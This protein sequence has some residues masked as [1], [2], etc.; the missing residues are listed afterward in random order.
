MNKEKILKNL[1]LSIR[2]REGRSYGFFHSNGHT[3]Q[4]EIFIISLHTQKEFFLASLSDESIDLFVNHMG[5]SL[6]VTIYEEKSGIFFE[7]RVTKNGRKN[8][9]RFDLTNDGRFFDRRKSKREELKGPLDV[10]F[11]VKGR[12]Y[13]K[14]CVD[15]SEK[16]LSFIISK[17]DL[18]SLKENTIINSIEI[19]LGKASVTLNGKIASIKKIS[20]HIDNSTYYCGLRI[21]IVFLESSS[22][23]KQILDLARS[24]AFAR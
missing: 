18:F 24:Q 12:N 22:K 11:S 21:S 13:R 7:A 8:L 10:K 5:S 20:P 19:K 4:I 9:F 1:E 2:E 17:S 15:V 3:Y 16:G 14:M 23:F 6:K